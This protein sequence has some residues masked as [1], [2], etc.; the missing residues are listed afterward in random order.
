MIAGAVIAAAI[1]VVAL[2]VFALRHGGMAYDLAKSEA[3]RD[4]LEVQLR[5]VV[6]DDKLDDAASMA[7]VAELLKEQEALRAEIR[8]RRRPG[9]ALARLRL[10]SE[11]EGEA[12][13]D[14]RQ[15]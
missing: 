5:A 6:A 9:D 10:L 12:T 15:D 1:A 2:V 11:A 4:R 3:D 13:S 14:D 8:R 7:R